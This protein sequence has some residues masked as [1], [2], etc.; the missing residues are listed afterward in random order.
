MPKISICRSF[1]HYVPARV[2][3]PP[4]PWVTPPAG[5][6]GQAASGDI[7]RV[8]AILR[9]PNNTKKRPY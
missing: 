7:F 6:A 5:L 8:L 2:A 3:P 4:D 1:L 9:T